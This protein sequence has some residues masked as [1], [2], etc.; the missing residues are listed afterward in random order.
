MKKLSIIAVVLLTLTM[1]STM[2]IFIP[3]ESEA[4]PLTV[5]ILNL[6]GEPPKVDVSPG[7]SGIIKFDGT[8]SCTKY[9][10]DQVKVFLQAQSDTGGASVIPPSLVFTGAGGSEET[11]SFA[12]TT[13]VPQG[14]TFMAT[15]QVT[16]SGY[17]VQGGLQYD[18]S[19]VTQI[20]EIEP[21]Y[22]LQVDTPP[23]Q[24]IGAGEF[25]HFPIK[26][27]NVGNSEDTYRFEFLN[28][29]KLQDNQW[30]VATITDKTF[31]EDEIK[32]LTVSAQAPQTWTIWRN[33]VTPFNLRI[34]SIQSEETAIMVR[35][36]VPLYVRQKGIYIPGF[37]PVFAIMGIGIVA[38]IMGKR[39]FAG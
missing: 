28:L 23:P 4:S 37:S 19:S 30:T 21:Y 10:P 15:P 18:A 13:R 8:V 22:K 16:V 24:E 2:L 5:V 11:K 6:Q 12:V 36:D 9:G 35:Y 26:I 7:S 38:L 39:R 14:Y 34:T 33:E 31:I 29:E 20:I 32:T 17:F 27:Q 3:Q 1:L 25:V